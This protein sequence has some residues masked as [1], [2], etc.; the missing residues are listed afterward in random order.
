MPKQGSPI[1]KTVREIAGGAL[2]GGALGLV[3][4]LRGWMRSDRAG[5]AAAL[6]EPRREPALDTDIGTAE[7]AAE[8][9]ATPLRPGWERVAREPLPQPTYWPAAL[10]FAITLVAWG[11]ATTYIISA[12]GGIIFVVSLLGWMGD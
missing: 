12:I 9:L 1:K 4:A 3:A 7:P 5:D 11:I 10:A 6:D 2:L 8:R